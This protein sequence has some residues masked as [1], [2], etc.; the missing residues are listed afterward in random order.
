MVGLLV[1]FPS[2]RLCVIIFSWCC[3]WAVG[4]PCQVQKGGHFGACAAEAEESWRSFRLREVYRMLRS[5]FNI[6]FFISLA[7]SIE[8]RILDSFSPIRQGVRGK[9]RWRVGVGVGLTTNAC[10]IARNCRDFIRNLGICI[11]AN[12]NIEIQTG[13]QR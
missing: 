4:W 1:S 8:D 3:V 12:S 7:Q 5:P 2:P 10:H 13:G 6:L 11:Q 9:Y